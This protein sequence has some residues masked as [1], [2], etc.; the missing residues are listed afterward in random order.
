MPRGSWD[1]TLQTTWVEPAYVEPDASWCEPGGEPASPVG[2][3][4]AFGGKLHSPVAADARRLADRHGR[5]VRVLWSREDVVRHGPKR[6]PVAGGHRGPTA[7]GVLRVGVPPDGWPRGPWAAVEAAVADGGPRPRP[8]AGP[9]PGPA[10]S[11]DLRAAVWAEAAVLAAC[12]RIVGRWRRRP[13]RSTTYR[14]RS[15]A[16]AGA[17]PRPAAGPTVRSRWRSM[18]VRCSTRWSCAPT[19]IGAAHQ[20]LG[21]VG[22]EGIAVERPGVVHDLTMRSFGILPARDMPPVTVA[23]STR[24]HRSAGQRLRRGVRRGG[25][26]PLAGRRPP[27][28]VAHA[29]PTAGPSRERA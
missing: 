16:P 23:V 28:P 24:R 7:S 2:N 9:V 14:S 12:A 18:A 20:A 5:P 8:R 11:F 26:R 27:A 19:A 22:T 15:P 29:G 17:G 25:R 6:P 4:G 21:W 3:G 13:H 1:L 10:V